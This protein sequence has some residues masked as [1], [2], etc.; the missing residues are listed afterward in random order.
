VCG[1]AGTDLRVAHTKRQ[2]QALYQE[3]KSS[4]VRFLNGKAATAGEGTLSQ[5]RIGRA[6]FGLAMKQPIN[7]SPIIT[8]DMGA[9]IGLF[10]LIAINLACIGS[11]VLGWW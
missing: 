10:A 9:I 5:H 2:G 1:V 6:L 3:T 7:E 11:F 8:H 4:L